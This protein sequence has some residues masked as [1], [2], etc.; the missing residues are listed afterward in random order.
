MRKTYL[1]AAC[2]LAL[3]VAGGFVALR[4][5]SW[6][7]SPW[8]QGEQIASLDGVP[9]YNNGPL[10]VVSHGRNYAA[11]GYYFGQKWQCVEFIKRYLYTARG[12]RMPDVM[13]HAVSFY[14]ATVPHRGFNAKRGM[15]QFAAGRDER[16]IK[17][18]LIVFGGAGGYGHVGIVASAGADS[19]TIAQQNKAP[20][21]ER[22]KLVPG[23]DGKGV[24]VASGL[25]VLGWLR[26]PERA[27]AKLLE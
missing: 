6:Q 15:T 5:V 18:D 26:A 27:A 1:I 25:P 21:L 8:A 13:S 24:T 14:D 17:G 4:G 12:H 2:V 11:D 16:P 20:A 19:I 23:V 7:S 10:F 9:V 3:F 22:L